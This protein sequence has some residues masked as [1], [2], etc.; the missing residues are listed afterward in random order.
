M[1]SFKAIVKDPTG[2]HARPATLLV[3]AATKFK[4]KTTIKTQTGATGDAKSIINLMALAVKQG[5]SFEV[6]FE[7]EDEDQAIE[8]VKKSLEDNKII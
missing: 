5:D 7:G 6:I 8:A 3:Q 2:L 1:K 4:S